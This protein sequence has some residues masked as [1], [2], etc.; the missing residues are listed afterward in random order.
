MRA[1]IL[2]VGSELLG[3][4]R[5]DTNSLRLTRA[6]ETF[7]VTLVAKEVIGD[8]H[9]LLV[10]AFRRLL[11]E[12]DLVLVTGGLGPTSDD[13]TREAA[14]EAVG[15]EL[16]LDAA[17]VE[18]I[19]RRFRAHG[20]E[21]PAVNERQGWVVDGAR[22]I[23]NP[24]GTAPGQCIE[25]DGAALFLFPG[26]PFELAAMI[27]RDLEPWLRERSA[28]SRIESAVLKVACLPESE[29]ER[30]I[31]AA[32]EE[33]GAESIS[34]LSKP[35][36]IRLQFRAAGGR[37]ARRR[38]LDAISRRLRQ[39]VGSAVFTDD[40]RQTLPGAVGELLRAR[41]QTVVTAESCTGGL[42]AERLTEVAGSSAYF[43]GSTVTYTNDSKVDWLGVPRERIEAHGAVSEE[44][45]RAMAEGGRER[46]NADW[47]LAVT[48]IAGPDGGSEEKP[49][50]TVH[51]A[52]AGRPTAGRP[53][54]A[55]ATT[56]HRHGRFPGDRE[57]VRRLSS[58]H[59]LEMLR[60]RLL[61]ES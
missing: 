41:G 47:C 32:Y 11:A 4:D 7:G 40:P 39:L 17:I 50:G 27:E 58:Q 43:L 8:D 23:D 61:R 35:G 22:V 29:V 24:R 31:A 60:R 5:L 38:R 10:R 25:H 14:A 53:A 15:R 44:V 42:V 1:A 46:W 57:R 54:T 6:L 56:H 49:V 33:F 20:M 52:L 12:V 34:V 55:E 2:A 45:A 13:L 48:G 28:G 18:S 9:A 30:R 16:R 36:E 21:M 19:A 3:T 37:D 51:L 26:V 59:A